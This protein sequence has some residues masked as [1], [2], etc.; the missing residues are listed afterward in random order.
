[1][2][3]YFKFYT[4]I[5][6]ITLSIA[7]IF[8]LLLW[9]SHSISRKHKRYFTAAACLTLGALFLEY[10]RYISENELVNGDYTDLCRA[11]SVIE[12][13]LAPLAPFFISLAAQKSVSL[14]KGLLLLIPA[15]ANLAM[16][17]LSGVLDSPY[18]YFHFD[19]SGFSQGACFF[20]FISFVLFY[21]SLFL[22]YAIADCLRFQQYTNAISPLIAVFVLALV[23]IGLECFVPSARLGW[24][25]LFLTLVFYLAY[26]ERTRAVID[27]VTHLLTRNKLESLRLRKKRYA[28]VMIDAD[29]FK[30]VNDTYGHKVGDDVLSVIGNAIRYGFS[31]GSIC[32]RYGGD[33][34][35]VL[36]TKIDAIVGNIRKVEDYLHEV[37]ENAPSI[38]YLSYGFA[39]FYGPDGFDEAF[40]AA[41]KSMYEAKKA[42]TCW[43]DHNNRSAA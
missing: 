28:V 26:F 13:S 35:I 7:A 16:A 5:L 38:S 34:F 42:K 40:K 36:T 23:G 24:V 8:F 4:G 11:L 12:Y 29:N 39:E 2:S 43:S 33:E 6:A 21:L 15:F 20:L 17:V 14:K 25:C 19:D 32:F 37:R 18:L 10:G 9:H 41:D 3:D 30:N 31:D 1:M 22:G 27:S